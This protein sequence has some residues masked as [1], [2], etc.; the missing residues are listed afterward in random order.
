M[1]STPLFI[2]I[3]GT[4]LSCPWTIVLCSILSTFI[5]SDW[6]VIKLHTCI[7]STS[8]NCILILW[9]FLSCMY[10]VCMFVFTM[11]STTS[12]TMQLMYILCMY[13]TLKVMQ[14][15]YYYNMYSYSFNVHMN[16]SYMYCV[17]QPY[18]SLYV[19]HIILSYIW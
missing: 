15:R 10:S 12:N 16:M 14:Q 17:V 9:H 7:H 18:V 11:W 6:L 4:N 13:V 1:G 5:D 19:L 8:T 2:K 3:W